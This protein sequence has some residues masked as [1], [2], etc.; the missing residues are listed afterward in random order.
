MSIS[1]FS[2]EFSSDFVRCCGFFSSQAVV[3]V[4]SLLVKP[5]LCKGLLERALAG[6]VFATILPNSCGMM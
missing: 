6:D 1:T 3:V 4:H 2:V 5:V